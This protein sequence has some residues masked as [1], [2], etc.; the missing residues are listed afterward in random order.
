MGNNF[1]RRGMP[2][3][4]PCRQRSELL[5]VGTILIDASDF[6]PTWHGLKISLAAEAL[7]T[8]TTCKFRRTL[9]RSTQSMRQDIC[10]KGGP[11]LWRGRTICFGF[12]R[13]LSN[14]M[15]DSVLCLASPLSATLAQGGDLGCGPNRHHR[16]CPAR[17]AP[18]RRGRLRQRA[19]E[20]AP[21]A[22]GYLKARYAPCT[23]IASVPLWCP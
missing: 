2:P 22:V 7:A 6:H 20:A 23:Y 10:N 21:G 14:T 16:R 3:Y 19:A 17:R 4:N 1:A 8:S 15:I 9:A 5:D 18:G 12:S 13:T 11:P